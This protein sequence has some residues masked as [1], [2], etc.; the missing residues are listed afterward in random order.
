MAQEW[1]A[2][3]FNS[4]Y[5]HL[6]YN[7]RNK[8]EAEDFIG[9]LVGKLNLQQGARVLDLACGKGRH[10]ITLNKLGF[11]TTGVDLSEESIKHAS[12]FENEHLHFAVHDMRNVLAV[13]YFD[14]V[15]NLFTSFG[16]LNTYREDLSVAKAMVAAAK[17]GGLIVVDFFNAHKVAA[18]V[19]EKKVTTEQREN[20]VVFNIKKAIVNNKVHKSI[21]IIDNGKHIVTHVEQVQLI[22]LSMFTKFFAGIAKLK[23]HF[24]SY[25]LDVFDEATSDRLIMIF[26]KI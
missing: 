6:L 1:F 3:W 5:Y 15:F 8:Q 16:Y 21:E 18:S 11:D 13:N 7:K 26:E 9:G 22:N 2:S 25:T 23:M 17:P 14:A 10:S 19:D 12:T 24:G 20:N 4:P